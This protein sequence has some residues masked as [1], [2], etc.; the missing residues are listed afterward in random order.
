MYGR[1]TWLHPV[2]FGTWVRPAA[3]IGATF[4]VGK[5][6]VAIMIGEYGIQFTT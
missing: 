2:G 4:S 6:P 3:G 1:R 5:K